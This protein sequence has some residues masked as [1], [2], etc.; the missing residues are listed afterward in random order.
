M[1]P[2][3]GRRLENACGAMVASRHGGSISVSFWDEGMTFVRERGGF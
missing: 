2:L 3:E 1:G